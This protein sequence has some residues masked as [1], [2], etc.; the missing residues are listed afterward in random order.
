MGEIIAVLSGKGGT[1]KTTVCAGISCALAM[2]GQRVL[3][4][5][6][7]VGL[8]NLDIALGIP[9]LGALSFA[10][11]ASGQYDLSQATQHPVYPRLR[12]LTAPA[13]CAADE[14]DLDAF[15][16][17]LQQAAMEFDFILL[18]APAGVEAGFSLTARFADRI[19]LITGQDPAA[20][21]D[22]SRAGQLLAQ[23]DKTDIRLVVNR[24]NKKMITATGMNIDDIMDQAG[25]P[26]WGV[27]PEDPNVILA[28]AF[29]QPLLGYTKGGAAAAC[30][31]IARRI[32][33]LSVPVKL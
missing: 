17:L 18:D 8:R 12:F 4:I 28:S 16:K 11:V 27:I 22:A 24:V 14:V 5:D 7:D 21:R 6:C 15:G 3:V 26:L 10:E 33:G 32:R 19:M 2:Q 1:G 25:L 9:E 13:A 30:R 31:R 23:M 29:R 20:I